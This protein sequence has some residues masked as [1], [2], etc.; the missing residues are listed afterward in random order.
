MSLL[1]VPVIHRACLGA[2]LLTYHTKLK[3]FGRDQW[4]A[5]RQQFISDPVR[6][7][8]SSEHDTLCDWQW[9]HKQFIILDIITLHNSGGLFHHK[10]L[11]R[12]SSGDET[13]N[14]NFLTVTSSTTFTQCAPEAT[15]FGE[16]MQNK[17]HYTAQGHSRSPIRDQLIN[18]QLIVT[19]LLSCT[20]SEI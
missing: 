9:L 7:Q 13:A 15:E 10:V 17:G 2:H 20:I 18:Y 5:Q 4:T 3:L 11:T 19:Y 12:N 14:V 16:I 6:A 1:H 8:C